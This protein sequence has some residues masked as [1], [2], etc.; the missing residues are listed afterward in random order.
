M[1]SASPHCGNAP[2][3]ST[4][5]PTLCFFE[6]HHPGKLSMQGVSRLTPGSLG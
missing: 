3:P 4:G 5:W 1:C 2:T 6:L